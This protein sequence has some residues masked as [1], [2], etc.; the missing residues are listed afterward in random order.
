[1]SLVQEPRIQQSVSLLPRHVRAL[2]W[3]SQES[4]DTNLSA[5]I[6]ELI[7]REMR[8]RVGRDWPEAL[9]RI[10]GRAA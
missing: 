4:G 8:S 9:D 2:R 5:T 6:R 10:E 1:M 7:E 3:L